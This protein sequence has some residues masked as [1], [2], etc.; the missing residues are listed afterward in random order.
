MGTG[1]KGVKKFVESTWVCSHV[2]G[3]FHQL[4]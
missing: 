4:S 3:A 2:D 1:K